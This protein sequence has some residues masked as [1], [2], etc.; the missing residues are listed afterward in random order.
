[1]STPVADV[2]TRYFAADQRRDVDAIVALFTA[3]AVVVDEG[4]TWR[5]VAAIRNWQDGPASQYQYTTAVHSAERS[6]EDTYCVTGRLDGNFPGG[7]ADL[8][9]RLTVAGDLISRLEIAP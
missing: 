3:D 6:A 1:M 7:T 9:W 4:Q 8:T 5:G 2:I